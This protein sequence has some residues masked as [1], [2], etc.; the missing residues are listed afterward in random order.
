MR[1]GYENPEGGDVS[2]R[3]TAPGFIRQHGALLLTVGTQFAMFGVHFGQAV[4]VARLLGPEDRG[5]YATALS[6]TQTLLYA[7]LLGTLLSIARRAATSQHDAE[8]VRRAALRTGLALGLVNF[9]IVALLSLVALPS[10]KQPLWWLCLACG[11]I[12]PLEQM[13][14]T[15]LAVDHGTGCYRRYNVQRL[16][17]VL[18]YPGLLLLLW[19]TGT[20]TL[21]SILVAAVAAPVVGLVALRWGVNGSWISGP[22]APS[23]GTL[24]REGLPFGPAQVASGLFERLDTWLVLYL[25]GYHMQG[26]YAVA[27]PAASLLMIA[28]HAL[29][30]F[31]F[32]A[33]ARSGSQLTRRQLARL[34]GGLLLV[35]IA[36]G[37][38]FAIIAEY[39]IPMAFGSQF[40]DAVGLTLLLLP[41]YAASGMAR[42]AE[43]YLQGRSRT[44]VGIWSRA[45]G[46][47]VTVAGAIVLARSWGEAGIPVAAS[48][49]HVV[50][51]VCVVSVLI[52]EVWR[53]T[54]L[55]ADPSGQRSQGTDLSPRGALASAQEAS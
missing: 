40:S 32:T 26:L 18:A 16:I 29:S 30:L 36:S 46:A 10:S 24:V 14:L 13:R 3:S 34:G 22:R 47:C 17:S 55:E 19:S 4:L 52:Q 11:L 51:S 23:A 48:L 35:Q 27:V 28:P 39:L 1:S 31:A 6:Y 53:A 21:N 41:G 45:V 42:T 8:S 33:G 9:A 44:A 43:A 2:G 12:L 49:G 7:G 54:R 38:V 50:M 20:A 25:V 5:K 15:M 37:I